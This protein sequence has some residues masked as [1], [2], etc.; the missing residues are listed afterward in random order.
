M[1]GLF[2]DQSSYDLNAS[3]IEMKEPYNKYLWREIYIYIYKV[4]NL[5]DIPKAHRPSL[6][7]GCICNSLSDQIRVQEVKAQ[8]GSV[9]VR[10][11]VIS[12]V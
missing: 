7:D 5:V 1:V 10:G 6:A 2:Y 4:I 3:G 9:R 11:A 8:W 12:K